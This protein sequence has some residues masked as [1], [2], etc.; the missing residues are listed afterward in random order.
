MKTMQ[1]LQAALIAVLLFAV[2]MPALAQSSTVTNLTGCWTMDYRDG[3]VVDSESGEMTQFWPTT[4]TVCVEPG[5]RNPDGTHSYQGNIVGY[6]GSSVFVYYVTR[7]SRGTKKYATFHMY[8]PG[9]QFGT[10]TPPAFVVVTKLAIYE[11]ENFG[12][13][14]MDATHT[15]GEPVSPPAETINVPDTFYGST[16]R[17]WKQY[18]GRG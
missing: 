2:A 15:E 13:G 17:A 5:Q 3:F 9:Q 11:A 6:P 10:R 4:L 7:V 8:F 12:H 16:V 18:G 14:G 1:K